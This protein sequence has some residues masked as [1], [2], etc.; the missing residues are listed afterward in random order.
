MRTILLLMLVI[1]TGLY[2]L[3]YETLTVTDAGKPLTAG[4]I[5][6]LS[7]HH[8]HATTMNEQHMVELSGLAWSE[9][10]Q[11]LYAINDRGSL[12]HFRLSLT[13]D[14]IS[15]I[16]LKRAYVLRGQNGTVLIPPYN[17]S[18]GLH[19]LR[20]DNGI[21]GDEK[22]LVSFE[23]QPRLQWHKPNGDFLHYEPL[24]EHLLEHTSYSH[25]NEA[26]ESVT[27]HK[28]LGVLT[29]PELPLV[30]A[31]QEKV[32]FYSSNGRRYEIPR[33]RQQGLSVCAIESMDDGSLMI[34][35]RRH[36]WLSPNWETELQRI[37]AGTGST[38]NTTRLANLKSDGKIPVDNYEGL[39]H[40]K[41]NRFFMV[42]DNNN[43]FFQKTLLIY[44]EITDG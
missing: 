34:L 16:D 18:E 10:E 37:T 14:K 1:P 17:D 43:M 31:E 23:G 40:H 20:A 6:I 41:A 22:L 3:D 19:I 44:F 30:T 33:D 42:S 13:G 39:A 35:L 25:G 38:L 28:Q 9:D 29:A 15:Q 26:L 36:R 2:A 7:I 12:F 4:D 27:I 24:P 8:L 21:T 11:T 32:T 5:R